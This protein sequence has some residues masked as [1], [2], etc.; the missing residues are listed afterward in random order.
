MPCDNIVDWNRNTCNMQV[1]MERSSAID[2]HFPWW[3]QDK[4]MSLQWNWPKSIQINGD[5]LL[6]FSRSC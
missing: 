3:N 6:K 2:Q 5:M 4:D 1:G